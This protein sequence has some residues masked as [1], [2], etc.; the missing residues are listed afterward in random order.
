MRG[1]PMIESMGIIASSRFK[2][3]KT[4]KTQ[5]A[6]DEKS[7]INLETGSQAIIELMERKGLISITPKGKIFLTQKGQ[8]EQLRCFL[9]NSDWSSDKKF[10]RFSRNK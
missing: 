7:A 4:L 3:E 2:I 10:V 1:K 9:I 5:H 6:F 8:E